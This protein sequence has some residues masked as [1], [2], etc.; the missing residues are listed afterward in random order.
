ML[1]KLS[2]KRINIYFCGL[3]IFNDFAVVVFAFIFSYIFRFYS[4][5]LPIPF[6]VPEIGDYFFPLLL[7]EALLIS[8]INR[9]GLYKPQPTKKFIDQSFPLVKSVCITMLF[10]FTGTFFYREVSY[11]RLLIF[12]IWISMILSLVGSRYFWYVFYRKK[13]LPKVKKDIIIVGRPESVEAL[14]K[15]E[16][17]FNYYGNIIGFISTRKHEPDN[18]GF[19]NLGHVDDFEQILEKNKPDEI[20]LADLELP[21]KRIVAMILASEKMLSVFKI[22]AEL[23]DVMVQQFEL[24]NS[25]GLNLIKIK[26]SPLNF[27]YNRALKRLIDIFG[28]LLGL[29]LCSPIFLIVSILVKKGSKGPVFFKQERIREGGRIFKIYKFRTMRE[30]A[31]KTTGPVFVKKND[32]RC[33]RLGKF[34]RSSNID[35]L[36]QLF[37]VLKGE[38]SLVGPRPERPY[39]VEQFKDDIPRYMS[40]HHI[41][42][43]ITGWAQV[44]G[45]RQGTSIDE[46]VKYDLYYAENWSVWLD[47]KIVFLSFFALKNAY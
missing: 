12:I 36:P 11:S 39:F 35:E 29:I 24:E 20:I 14:K 21:R 15:Q 27:T 10:V 38:M 4:G 44:H 17:Y 37:N 45:L 13:I 23:L 22:V 46:R 7:V 34:L 28:S 43:G 41:K 30:D 5:L 32:E 3:L 42:P 47:L 18:T 31:E 26:E 8:I 40:R 1:N 33:T 16:K 2:K 25:G 6:G 9:R 19:K